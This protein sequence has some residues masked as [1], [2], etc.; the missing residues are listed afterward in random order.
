MKGLSS[1][2]TGGLQLPHWPKKYA[3]YHVFS[4]FEADFCSKNENSPPQRDLRA[5]VMKHLLLVGPEKSHLKLVRK[6]D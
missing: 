3:K 6:T 5:E 1:V 2:A 4:A